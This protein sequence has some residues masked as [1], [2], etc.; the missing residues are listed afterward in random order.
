MYL[1]VRNL[2]FCFPSQI[3]FPALDIRL[4]YNDVQL[5]L[6]I[7]KSIPAT[8]ST[9]PSDTATE[10]ESS[11]STASTDTPSTSKDSFR[12]KTEALLGL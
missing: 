11:A 9:G 6:A 4:S 12:H 7:A 2:R 5:F 8:G 10:A 3:Q 1:Y